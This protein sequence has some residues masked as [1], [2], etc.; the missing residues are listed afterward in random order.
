[1]LTSVLTAIYVYGD[2]PSV[3]LPFLSLTLCMAWNHR[4]LNLLICWRNGKL[5]L[6]LP[7]TRSVQVIDRDNKLSYRF[8]PSSV[9]TTGLDIR[10]SS[11][12]I[13]PTGRWM[14][15]D[16]CCNVLHIYVCVCVCVCVWW[17][18][19]RGRGSSCSTWLW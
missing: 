3:I 7:W 19:E 9:E 2:H 11:S 5:H 12:L 14:F 16:A 1:M 17:E 4:P 10:A 15:D 13:C 6:L 18:R 8:V